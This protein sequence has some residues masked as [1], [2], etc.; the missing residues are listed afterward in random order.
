MQNYP[1]RQTFKKTPLNTQKFALNSAKDGH[2]RLIL[3]A[4]EYEPKVP[5]FRSLCAL[6]RVFRQK[7][8]LDAYKR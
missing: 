5:A 6:Q 1:G 3:E 2:F 7:T 8:R 4:P